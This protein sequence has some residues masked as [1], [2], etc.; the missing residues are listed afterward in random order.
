M[1]IKFILTNYCGLNVPEDDIKC[2]FFTVISIDSLLAYESKY[3]LQVFLE[4]YAYI[5]ANKQMT[6]YLDDIFSKLKSV[7]EDCGYI[8]GTK[9]LSDFCLA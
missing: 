6:D 4:N 8:V 3:C 2:E 5:I 7:L 1:V 9:I